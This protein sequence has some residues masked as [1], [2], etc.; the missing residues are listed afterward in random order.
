MKSTPA[1][2]LADEL[3]DAEVYLDGAI[4]E[5]EMT[6]RSLRAAKKLLRIRR[7]NLARA[8]QRGIREEHPGVRRT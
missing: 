1:S 7:M 2:K 8:I 6:L 4:G 3:S 5:I